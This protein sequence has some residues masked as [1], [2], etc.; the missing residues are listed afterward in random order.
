MQ[1]VITPDL[2]VGFPHLEFFEYVTAHVG[3]VAAALFLVIGLGLQPRRGAVRRVLAITVAYTVFVGAF[4]ATTGSDYMFLAAR[5]A[6]WSLLSVMGPW[7]WYVVTAT[8]VAALLLAL[9]DL[10]FRGVPHR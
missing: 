7:P 10:P 4:D 9:L 3:I 8:G 6:T 5:P 1:A 2:R